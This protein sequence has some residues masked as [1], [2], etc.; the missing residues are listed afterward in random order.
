MAE[1]DR[2]QRK[3]ES[4]VVANSESGSRQLKGFVDNRESKVTQMATHIEYATTRPFGMG[5]NLWGQPNPPVLVGSGVYAFLDRQDP[6]RGSGTTHGGALQPIM[7]QLGAGW[8]QGHLLNSNTGGV[9]VNSNLVPITTAANGYHEALVERGVKTRL[10]NAPVR[11]AAWGINHD[12]EYRVVSLPLNVNYGIHNPE[13]DLETHWRYLRPTGH[14]SAWRVDTIHSGAGGFGQDANWMH[15]NSGL[16]GRT[17]VQPNGAILTNMQG[18]PML[19][20]PANWP[21]GMNFAIVHGGNIASY[22]QDQPLQ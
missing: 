20:M 1:Y 12:V 4:R 17:V 18:V 11:N 10:H 19:P 8:V 9:A 16:V 13:V 22:H 14:W 21:A 3:P 6:V 2:Q 5:N 7:A 15:Q